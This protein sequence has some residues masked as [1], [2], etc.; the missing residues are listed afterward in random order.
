[1][2]TLNKWAEDNGVVLFD[3]PVNPKISF[4]YISKGQ[5]TLQIVLEDQGGFFRV[6]IW[7]VE[8]NDNH[9]FHYTETVAASKIVQETD[10]FVK[11]AQLWFSTRKL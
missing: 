8:T 7:P 1:M 6:D 9:E 10:R 2:D 11:Q 4:F 3:D 5:E